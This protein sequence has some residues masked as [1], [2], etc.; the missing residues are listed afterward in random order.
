MGA[1]ISYNGRSEA[2]AWCR[3]KI[4]NSFKGE[5]L[6]LSLKCENA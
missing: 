6:N 2:V 3:H 5:S 1:K 4:R